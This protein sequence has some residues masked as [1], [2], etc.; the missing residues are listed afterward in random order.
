MV[1]KLDEENPDALPTKDDITHKMIFKP[2][3]VVMMSVANV[4]MEYATKGE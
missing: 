2:Q 3:D 1:H 4:D